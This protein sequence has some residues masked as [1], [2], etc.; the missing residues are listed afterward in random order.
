MH[1]YIYNKIL[2]SHLR[3]Q[4]GWNLNLLSK[5]CQTKKDKDCN[6]TRTRSIQKVSSYVL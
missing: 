4:H 1:L 6:F 5:K 2:F 3:Q